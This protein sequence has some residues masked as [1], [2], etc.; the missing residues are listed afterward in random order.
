MTYWSAVPSW[1]LSWLWGCS[2]VFRP[3]TVL[4]VGPFVICF[5]LNCAFLFGIYQGTF[6]TAFVT[7]VEEST[8]FPQ[9]EIPSFLDSYLPLIIP[10]IYS[11]WL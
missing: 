8:S 11:V 7:P 3:S 9:V 2:L 5:M 1:L 4:V 6:S 10:Q